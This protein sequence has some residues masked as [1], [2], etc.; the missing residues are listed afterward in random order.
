MKIL[1]LL[2]SFTTGGTE[3]LVT[4]MA[5]EMVLRGHEV[6]LYIVNDRVDESML[7]GLD[8]A[9]HV[10]LQ[11]RPVGGGGRLGVLFRIA[12]YIR[13]HRI[14]VVHGNSIHVPD[15]LLLHPILYPGVRIVQ[16]VH[17]VCKK[18]ELSRA[19]WWI[20][21]HL[22]DCLIAISDSVRLSMIAMGADSRK[23]KIVYNGVDLSRFQVSEEERPHTPVRI[24][25][26]A[27]IMPEI[28][29]QDVLIRALARL[30]NT[31]PETECYFAGAYDR[32][33]EEAYQ[34]LVG[35]AKELGVESK[36]HFLGNVEDV[37]GFLQTVD[38]FALPSHCE[39]FGISLIEAMAME[40]PCIASRLDGPAEL[41]G[42]EKYGRLFPAGDDEALAEGLA[43]MIAA[44]P[45]ERQRAALARAQVEKR[46]SMS[47]MAEKLLSVYY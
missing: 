32:E 1:Y 16:T 12:R 44:Y 15:L 33:H 40:I 35:L 43:A 4:D 29:G 14:D 26:V 10:E 28:K 47:T 42:R 2:F 11:G 13:K 39:G 17:A 5:R 7:A 36:V 45:E 3:R 19:Q 27:R 34:E 22:C 23:V 6:H 8:P 21:N 37:P 20:R 30:Q 41:I 24:A 9:V 46:F 31:H 25:H 18:G 38:I